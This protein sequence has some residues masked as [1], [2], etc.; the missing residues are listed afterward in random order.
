[1]LD[2]I[3]FKREN[4]HKWDQK[5]YFTVAYNKL[6]DF[7]LH[8]IF[9]ASLPQSAQKTAHF[10]ECK[11]EVSNREY[12][13]RVTSKDLHHRNPIHSKQEFLINQPLNV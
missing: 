12:K 3:A 11:F 5:I 1:M 9:T 4:K 8:T 6:R 2:N 13:G 7:N 10:D